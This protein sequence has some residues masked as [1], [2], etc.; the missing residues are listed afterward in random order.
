MERPDGKLQ[1]NDLRFGTFR[2][3]GDVKDFIFRFLLVKGEGY[4][5]VAT[6]G[7]PE[8]DSIGDIFGDLWERVKG[9]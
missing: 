8:D 4:E 2:G 5:M 6:I 9:R 3:R 1:L 7:G